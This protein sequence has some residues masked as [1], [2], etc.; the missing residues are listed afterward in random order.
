MELI[1]SIENF[2]IVLFHLKW[3]IGFVLVFGF[4]V[5]AWGWW[6]GITV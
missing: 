2:V 3:I 6:K 4:G 1:Q 5:T